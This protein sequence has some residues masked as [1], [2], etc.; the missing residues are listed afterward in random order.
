L[1]QFTQGEIITITAV[2]AKSGL[3]ARTELFLTPY[4]VIT[5]K[6]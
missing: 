3:E 6:N 2:T 1:E 5:R 4:S